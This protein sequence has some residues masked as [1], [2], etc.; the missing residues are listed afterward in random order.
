[1]LSS[2]ADSSSFTIME[3]S[4][5]NKVNEW[6]EKRSAIKGILEPKNWPT[7]K[8]F[9]DPKGPY[10]RKWNIVFIVSCVLAVLLDPLF[11]YIPTIHEDMKC[12][13]LDKNMKI[14]ALVLRSV[15]DLC[16][17]LN[18]FFQL[19]GSKTRSTIRSGSCP[20]MLTSL[21]IVLLSIAKTMWES[22]II[23]DILAVLPLPQ[24]AIL[25]F[26]PKMRGSGSS[27]KGKLMNFLILV[28]Y[29]PRVLRIYLS[30]KESKKFSREETSL[31]LKGILNFFMYILA[32]HREAT[33]VLEKHRRG[34]CLSGGA[35]ASIIGP[36]LID[37]WRVLPDGIVGSWGSKFWYPV[38][39]SW[40][41]MTFLSSQAAMQAGRMAGWRSAQGWSR[42]SE[43]GSWRRFAMDR[44]ALIPSP[45]LVDHRRVQGCRIFWRLDEAGRQ[46]TTS[47][48]LILGVGSSRSGF[49]PGF[50]RPKV[51]LVWL[52]AWME[53]FRRCEFDGTDLWL[54][55][56][57]RSTEVEEDDCGGWAIFLFKVVFLV[58]SSIRV[59]VRF[60]W[61]LACP[62]S[63]ELGLGQIEVPCMWCFSWGRIGLLSVLSY[64]QCA[65]ERSLHVAWHLWDTVWKRALVVVAVVYEVVLGALCYFFAVQRITSCWRHACR[66]E[67]G[68]DRNN[69][70][71]HNHH[72][73][74]NITSLNDLCPIDPSDPKI[75][76]FGIFLHILQFGILGS[77]NYPEKFSNCFWWGLRHLS[78]LG[79]NLEPSIN[80]WENLFAAFI[81]II[82]LLLFLYL[83]GNLQTYMQLDTARLETDRWNLRVENKLDEKSREF[84]P[85][86]VK[87]G[88]PSHKKP[89]IMAKVLVELKQ[90]RDVDIENLL[91][92]LPSDLQSYVESCMPLSRLKK[93]PSVQNMAE[94]VLREISEN[95]KPKKYKKDNIIISEDKPL[96]MMIFI[97]DGLVSIEKRDASGT[98]QRGAGQL[99]GEQLLCWPAWTSF[100]G[101]SNESARAI[102]DVDVLVLMAS[103]MERVGYKFRSEFGKEI[104][105]LSDAK[106]VLLE[107][108]QVAMLR[109]VPKLETMH[110][111][112]LKAIS[113]HLKPRSYS[114]AWLTDT[115]EPLRMM[116]FVIDGSVEE[117]GTL[118]HGRLRHK[119]GYFSGEELLDYVLD[120]SFPALSPLPTCRLNASNY[121]DILYV[122][123]KDLAS[124]AS[125]YRSNFSRVIAHPTDLF[126]SLTLHWLKKVPMFRDMDEEVV[127][128]ISKR[129]K[130]VSYSSDTVIIEKHKPLEMMFVLLGGERVTVKETYPYHCVVGDFI[131][132]ELVHWITNWAAH[133]NFPAKLPL[134]HNSA[135]V[136]NDD[137]IGNAE[138]AV[139]WADDLK[140]IVSE[141]RSDFMK[142][143]TLPI[144]SE[145]KLATFDPLTM[146]KKVPILEN[147]DEEVLK[148]I[149]S[150]LNPMKYSDDTPDGPF[151]LNSNEKI[152]RMFFIIRGIVSYCSFSGPVYYHYSGNYF[153][154]QL[155]GWVLDA[156]VHRVPELDQWDAYMSVGDVEVLVL[157]AEDLAKVIS[158]FET[159]FVR[160]IPQDSD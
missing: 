93:V 88:I 122:T 84:E 33:R 52:A 66:N 6:S 20:P 85:W 37:E 130:R 69:F 10:I 64:G 16:Y 42:W 81:S 38:Q 114:K 83:I 32:S 133:T 77:T 62:Y 159:H 117:Y 21:R 97:V 102:G 76:D 126:A 53:S 131:G 82:G 138:V 43:A 40:S 31:W 103:D 123:A 124:V 158:E 101:I 35:P 105:P 139:L 36:G 135:K 14:A 67:N 143:T 118:D 90:N 61:F 92:I 44:T 155:L 150:H 148:A 8:E 57:G 108:R 94:A 145:G 49:M 104:T 79:S 15:T 30:C 144:D 50:G 3:K 129:M 136:P 89:D 59:L 137:Q 113:L 87:N 86:L 19:C 120:S 41:R 96:E 27:I 106:W 156:S 140:S 4:S 146:V 34:C 110:T 48:S 74:R 12:V 1:M 56:A 80:T 70:D 25:I 119:A 23:I 22:Y 55:S 91:S 132:L 153:G 17:L 13:R 68:C 28:Q 95:L 111:E 154:E 65:D 26:F 78:S 45:S 73:L 142:Q 116:I 141:F 99:F 134:S 151:I 63:V 98:L 7:R 112:V 2:S 46:G 51:R 157:M 9:V 71:C 152:D 54:W 100:P 127:K 115:N 5:T 109:K 24:V 47:F 58:R 121:V 29:V 18:I 72:T 60:F 107:S 11:L 39:P 149:C 160:Q 147:M 128:E 125:E 75:F